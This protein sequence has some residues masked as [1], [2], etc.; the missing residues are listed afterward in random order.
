MLNSAMHGPQQGSCFGRP[1]PWQHHSSASVCRS[2]WLL[3]KFLHLHQYCT[4]FCTG[5]G[6]SLIQQLQCICWLVHD[7]LLM[8]NNS[9]I[10]NK[11]LRL[12]I[13]HHM[14]M[15]IQRSKSAPC[16]TICTTCPFCFRANMRVHW[17]KACLWLSDKFRQRTNVNK[18]CQSRMRKMMEQVIK[19]FLQLQTSSAGSSPSTTQ[20]MKTY[21]MLSIC[22]GFNSKI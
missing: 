4:M 7:W 3:R 12:D 11:F 16:C 8:Y 15:I 13:L 17:A 9:N 14:T 5:N 2:R 21:N 1:G 20:A 18:R 10:K 19:L 22:Q 6:C